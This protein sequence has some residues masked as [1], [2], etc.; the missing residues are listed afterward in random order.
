MTE[1]APLAV[2]AGSGLDLLSL[3]DDINEEIPFTD[4]KQLPA[5]SVAGH[6]G[7]FVLGRRR[8]RRIIVQMGR[9][10]IYEGHP[11]ATVQQP[12]DVLHDMG[13]RKVIFTNAAGGLA[14]DLRPGALVAV[15]RI[16]LWPFRRWSD[17]PAWLEAD[18]QVPGC[19]AAGIYVWV[20][21]PSYETP[22]EIAV[23]QRIDGSAVGMSTAAELARCKELGMRAG[24]VSC[25]TNQCGSQEKLTHEHVLDAAQAASASLVEVL[26]D[27]VDAHGS[28]NT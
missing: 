28:E 18:F 14:P 19:T 20:H 3:L 25:I 12:V 21:G 5:S 26:R 24:V 13:V 15:E 22:A 11:L 10:H 1:P 7:R 2:V 27:Y 4:C 8:G 9:L 6:A 16:F 17:A 23:M